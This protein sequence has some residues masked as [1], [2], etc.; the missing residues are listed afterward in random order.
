[1]ELDDEAVAEVDGWFADVLVVPRPVEGGAAVTGVDEVEGTGTALDDVGAAATATGGS[2]TWESA[3]PTICQVKTV[4]RTTAASQAAA[5]RQENMMRL[6][7]TPGHERVNGRS[8]FSQV[9]PPIQ[10]PPLP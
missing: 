8:R 10:H 6:S 9:G 3:S 5:I 1:M 7:Q 4:V 2:P